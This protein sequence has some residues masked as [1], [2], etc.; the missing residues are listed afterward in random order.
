MPAHWT[1]RM[2][3]WNRTTAMPAAIRGL[4]AVIGVATDTGIIWIARAKTY[5]PAARPKIPAA[6][7]EAQISRGALSRW[8]RFS[9]SFLVR[10]AQMPQETAKRNRARH[11]VMDAAGRSWTDSSHF[12]STM[13]AAQQKAAARARRKPF[14]EAVSGAAPG[15]FRPPDFSMKRP[16][17]M[18]PVP[19][20]RG[21]VT[22][23][24]SQKK[25]MAVTKRG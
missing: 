20:T 12:W 17:I 3:S 14:H 9:G 6:T 8:S 10:Q 25:E 24:P 19:R 5:P 11:R 18:T 13:T 2:D 7:A 15:A 23:S 16:A 22:D 1:G 4:V 21:R